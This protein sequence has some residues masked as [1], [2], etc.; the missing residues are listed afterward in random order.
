MNRSLRL[1]VA[2]ALAVAAAVPALHA[3]L[4]A[5]FAGPASPLAFQAHVE[6]GFLGFFSHKIQFDRT[7]PASTYFDYVKDGGQDIWFPFRRISGDILIGARHRV[8]F[9]YQP[10]DI[11]TETR[12]PAGGITIDT[13]DFLPDTGLE[14]RYGFDFYR[15]SYL[16]DFFKDPRDELAVGATLQ[17]RDAT[18]VFASKDGTAL[19]DNTNIGPV[20]ALKFRAKHYLNDWFWLGAEIDGVYA[21]GKGATGSLDVSDDF[22]GAILDASLRAGFSPREPVDVFLNLRYIGGGAEGTATDD[23]G[24]GDG[25]TRNWLH[26]Y[27]VSIGVTVR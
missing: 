6:I 23:T 8:I 2:V 20:P 1:A 12:V 15:L 5:Q 18:I 13:V 10:F 7:D 26:T 22:V 11:R 21:A 19:V 17:I 16:Y 9:L 25:Y 4:G 3:E 24:P 27:A 14:L